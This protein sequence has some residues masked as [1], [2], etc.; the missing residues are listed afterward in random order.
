[1]STVHQQEWVGENVRF[2]KPLMES[3]QAATGQTYPKACIS[4]AD[5]P[6][7]TV[8]L[9][10]GGSPSDSAHSEAFHE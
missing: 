3:R 1:M 6:K 5:I 7:Q 2:E 9:K 8:P 4:A 10:S